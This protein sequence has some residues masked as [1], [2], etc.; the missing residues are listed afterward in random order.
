MPP[1]LLTHGFLAHAR[2]FAFIAPLLA[3]R[4]HL[5]AFDMSGMGDSGYRAEYTDR[6]AEPIAVAEAAG[7]FAHDRRP[8]FVTH[9]FGGTT[10]I[11]SLE[12]HHDRFAG[13]VVCDLMMMREAQ[14]NDYL[15][16]DHIARLPPARAAKNKVYDD[17]ATAMGRF[18]LAPSQP[19]TNDYLIEYMARHSLK[20]VDG[21]WTWK[22][23]PAILRGRHD[24][25]WWV[26][27]PRRFAALP[28]RKAVI[29][30][31]RSI[32]FTE[33]S[34][35]YIRELAGEGVPIVGV[36]DAAHHLMLD[37][38][39]AFAAALEALLSSWLASDSSKGGR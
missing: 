16:R 17:L 7:L 36:A 27:I 12:A 24:M 11:Q 8:I 25:D 4:F 22:F 30:G 38:P 35:A 5:V 13:L 26:N 15:A 37:R 29:H 18:R 28:C 14:L 6:S 1:V 21:G 31:R 19:C 10:A 32:L 39:L 20:Q 34:A 2:A 9:S 3:R 23:D 33:D